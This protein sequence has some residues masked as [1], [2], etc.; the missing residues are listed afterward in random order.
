M[1]ESSSEP[2]IEAGDRL[3]SAM[4]GDTHTVQKIEDGK[5]HFNR[6]SPIYVDEIKED[7]QRGALTKV[8]HD[9][10][11]TEIYDLPT[12]EWNSG[13]GTFEEVTITKVVNGYHLDG[14]TTKGERFATFFS[15]IKATLESGVTQSAIGLSMHED[16]T[17]E[18]IEFRLGRD[19]LHL[20]D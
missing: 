2:S 20:R 18:D 5:A 11:N 13:A 1:E 10:I 17:F 7:L 19:E 4:T 3:K 16:L 14:Y 12:N 15:R 9:E 8:E 6:L